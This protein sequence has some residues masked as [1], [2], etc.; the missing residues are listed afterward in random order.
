[1]IAR[2]LLLTVFA[3]ALPGLASAQ[4]RPSVSHV[5]GVTVVSQ[6]DPSTAL[7]GVEVTVAAGLDREQ[8]Q[9]DGLA[10]L[11]AQSILE[12]PSEDGAPLSDAIAARGG[13]VKFTMEAHD[14][15]FYVEALAVDAPAVLALFERAAAAPDFS[16]ATVRAAR[17]ALVSKIAGRQQ[18]P[19]EVGIEMLDLAQADG[20][21]SGLPLFGTPMSL[22]QLAP[23]DANAFYRTYYRRGGASISAVGQVDALGSLVSL[24][25]MLPAGTTLA[26]KTATT[27]LR[28]NGRELVARRSIGAPWLVVR[29]GAP[30]LDSGD[31]GPMLVLSA[32][33][34]RTLGDISEVPGTI[35]PTLASQAV[36][37]M[38]DFD[39][40]PGQLVVYVDGAIDNDPNRIFQTA[41][42]VVNLLGATRLQG[43][44]DQ[45]KTTAAGDFTERAS[46]LE[47]RAWLADVFA[48]R[49]GSADYLGATLRAIARTTPADLQR[50]ARRYLENPTIALVLPRAT[51]LQN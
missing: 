5:A 8:L 39:G 29:Y 16:S 34:Q 15:R 32:F 24:A 10:A 9:Q 13:S 21:N 4:A 27:P 11:V 18:E 6:P 45:F 2:V 1:M 3:A 35:T 30:Q 26:V 20:A 28:G 7:A 43:S 50:V 14:V 23:A 44:I 36:G 37:A 49:T 41:L 47:D 51:T 40:T 33:L 31:Y 19:L 48:R 12:T 17:D 22:V 42:S 46:T 25:T 38:Y